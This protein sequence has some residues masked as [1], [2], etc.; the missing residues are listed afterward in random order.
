VT[1]QDFASLLA[2]GHESNGVEFKGRGNR[3]NSGF[4]AVVIRAVLG[5]ANRRDGGLV[6]I[7]VEADSLDPVGFDD[8]EVQPWLNPGSRRP[9]RANSVHHIHHAVPHRVLLGTKQINSCRPIVR[10][11]DRQAFKMDVLAIPKRNRRKQ[12]A[13]VRRAK[14]DRSTRFAVAGHHEGAVVSSLQQQNLSGLGGC[15]PCSEF[16]LRQPAHQS[17][18]QRTGTR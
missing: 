12:G 10:V 18:N 1:E 8:K 6:V 4:L 15:I 17:G 2:L 11:F 16:L 7:G 13:A 3:T 14:H 9:G 5:M